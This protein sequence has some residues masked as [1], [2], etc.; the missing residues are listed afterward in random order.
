MIKFYW[1]KSASFD[2][3][4]QKSSKRN[5]ELSYI[6]HPK[7]DTMRKP[8]N[9]AEC[10]EIG[11]VKKTHGVKGELQIFFQEGID[12]IIEELEYFF[13]EFEGHL[14]PF[15]IESIFSIGSNSA[16]ILFNTLSSKEEA[17]EFIGCK[18]FLEN[19]WFDRDSSPFSEELVVG[20]T[21][22]DP[23]KGEIGK[24]THINNYSGNLV[25]TID[26]HGKE[27]LIPFN[28]KLLHKFNI[29][30]QSLV[31]DCHEGLFDLND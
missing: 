1:H 29:K 31:M 27:L 7:E 11:F 15:F 20:L 13:F 21:L 4:K 10:T 28:E 12:E 2:Q 30:D 14:V 25:L 16:I 22:I 8:I 3:N 18:L 17:D 26:Y 6:C 24:I 5:I 9:K 19:E 23:V